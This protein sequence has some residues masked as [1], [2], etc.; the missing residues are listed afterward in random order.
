MVFDDSFTAIMRWGR[1][2]M[3]RTPMINFDGEDGVDYLG[4]S[5]SVCKF[6]TVAFAFV[7]LSS[8]S[9]PREWLSLLSRQI[10]HSSY[11][12]F[13]HST[14]GGPTLQINPSSYV[15]PKHLSRF[16]FLA[17]RVAGM[18][19]LPWCSLRHMLL[20]DSSR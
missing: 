11:T 17:R 7:Y 8:A 15:N 5:K 3:R 20:Q 4:I 12:L 18:A 9:R 2:D 6:A 14:S 13:T 16:G 10:L 1:E 19:T